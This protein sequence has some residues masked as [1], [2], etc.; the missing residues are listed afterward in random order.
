MRVPLS[1]SLLIVG[2]IDETPIKKSPAR[3][4][5]FR[6]CYSHS[7]SFSK[8]IPF[9]SNASLVATSIPVPSV[10]LIS[11]PAFVHR[12]RTAFPQPFHSFPHGLVVQIDDDRFVHT[13]VC[14]VIRKDTQ[15]VRRDIVAIH[16]KLVAVSLPLDVGQ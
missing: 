13:C 1:Q 4:G 14:D 8:Y 12:K 11:L 7:A 6:I 15:R 3:A 9:S 5:L 10:N 2:T 16:Q